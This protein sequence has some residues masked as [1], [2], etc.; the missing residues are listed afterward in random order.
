MW[1]PLREQHNAH[2]VQM[3]NASGLRKQERRAIGH[4]SAL[5]SLGRLTVAFDNSGHSIKG[6]SHM[7][8]RFEQLLNGSEFT[9]L[10]LVQAGIWRFSAG[11]SWQP[12]KRH[13]CQGWSAPR[14]ADRRAGSTGPTW[15]AQPVGGGDGG[16]PGPDQLAPL[17]LPAAIKPGA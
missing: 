7:G 17:N 16:G 8:Q 14:Y 2:R 11:V 9:I 13:C 12:S 5:A 3:S 6:F 10:S 15:R 4:V 1:K